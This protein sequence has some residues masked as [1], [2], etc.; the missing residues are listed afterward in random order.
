[1]LRIKTALLAAALALTAGVAFAQ[2]RTGACRTET[3][4]TAGGH[5]MQASQVDGF[6]LDR[7]P[8][9]PPP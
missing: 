8:T 2:M 3:C 7:R 1:M 5:G 9:R 4:S 6:A